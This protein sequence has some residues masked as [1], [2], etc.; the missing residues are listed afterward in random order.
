MNENENDFSIF[1]IIKYFIKKTV[2]FKG[3]VTHL[4]F[5][6]NLLRSNNNT[7]KNSQQKLHYQLATR[8]VRDREEIPR[9]FCADWNESPANAITKKILHNS[10]L[11]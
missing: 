1:F 5:L 4:S 7:F 3:C 11:T 2:I 10:L 8:C 9:F 6:K